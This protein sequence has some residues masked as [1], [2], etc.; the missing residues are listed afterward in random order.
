MYSDKFRF[1]LDTKDNTVGS[2]E[3]R[4]LSK[5]QKDILIGTLLGDGCLEVNGLYPRL[6]IDHTQ[7]QKEYVL[8]LFKEFASLRTGKPHDVKTLDKRFNKYYYHCRFS[9]RSVPIFRLWRNLF[10]KGKRK[11]IPKDIVELVK[12]PL[13]LAVWYM[14]DGYRRKDCKGAYLCTSAYTISEQK[15]LQ[16][17]LQR[18]FSLESRLHY[19]AGQVRIYIPAKNVESFF[20][21]IKS[22]I[23]PNF[24]YKLL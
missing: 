15:L 6:R 20:E 4:K 11:I 7:A 5:R 18:N 3:V 10:Y 17:V 9:T 2:R 19:A 12:S 1:I 24:S 21:K 8:W 14:D 23:L 16:K 13:S 22:Y